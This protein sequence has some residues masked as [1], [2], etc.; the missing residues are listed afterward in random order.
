M[1]ETTTCPKNREQCEQVRC[2]QTNST[3]L[4]IMGASEPDGLYEQVAKRQRTTQ[5]PPTYDAVCQ[6][7]TGAPFAESSATPTL[8]R[9]IPPFLP[10]VQSLFEKE[11]A[12]KPTPEKQRQFLGRAASTMHKG[13]ARV[14]LPGGEASVT[15]GGGSHDFSFQYG[16][17]YVV[18]LLD[19][20]R[21]HKL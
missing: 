21:L 10:A 18:P 20:L 4:E 11:L 16:P 9:R 12:A 5:Q 2:V 1:F 15:D 8:P 13:R 3:S 17:D 7:A 14:F 6:P 19:I